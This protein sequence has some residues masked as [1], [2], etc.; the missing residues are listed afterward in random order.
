[1]IPRSLVVMCFIV[2][3]GAAVAR[4]TP[5]GAGTR[6][7]IVLVMA[8]DLGFSDLGCYGGEIDT[9]HIDRLAQEGIRFSNFHVNSMCVV[10]RTSLLSGHTHYQSDGYRHSLPIA[11]RMRRAG[12]R[13]S[14]S[15]K[16]HQPGHPL[17]AG[18]DHFYGFLKGQIN[19]WTGVGYGQDSIQTDRENPRSVPAGWYAGDAFTEH[20]IRQ[21]DKA[22]AADK[23]FFS[24]VAYNAPHTPLHAPRENV[25]K[26]PP[27]YRAGW[28]ALR[29]KRCERLKSLG[30]IDGRY[31]QVE[32]GAE[33]RRWD[34]LRPE[35]R[36]IEANRMA[37]YAGM[38]DRLDENVGRLI[39]HLREKGVL[40]HTLVLFLS[41]NGGDYGN[42]HIQTYADQV[43]WEKNT[44]P[45][46]SN[47]W[48]WLKNTPFNWY[49]HSEGGGVRSPLILRWPEGIPHTPGTI[50]PHRLHITD[51]YPTF[52][53]L[54]GAEYPAQHGS[55]EL[56][57]LYGRSMVPLF[58]TASLDG[59]AIRDEIFWYYGDGVGQ[60]ALLKGDWKLMSLN[61]GPWMLFNVETDPGESRNMAALNPRK[62][63][64]LSDRWYQFAR[65][66]AQLPPVGLKPLRSEQEGWGYH[67]VA[68]MLPGLQ[69]LTPH[70]AE[71]GVARNT[72]L[73]LEFDR[74]VSFAGT[75]GKTL[76]LYAVGDP[77]HP[78]WQVDP[79]P[80][81]EWQG[82]TRVVFDNL[83]LLKPDTSYFLL[84]DAG[85]MLIDAR[86]A[87]P[88]NDGA[89][90]WRFRTK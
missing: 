13:T 82:K 3:L 1:M 68:R 65:E 52:L 12:Y 71:T 36:E 25:E 8:D 22:L 85:W 88:L 75:K 9:P 84:A 53:E 23:P 2:V 35:D 37:A 45:H 61:D 55:R 14:V 24:F 89:Y 38:V 54:A 78:L 81:S 56:K 15:G 6:P 26:Y 27:H 87:G 10:T 17:D 50:L 47:G 4:G 40:D 28:H 29:K 18:F 64:A 41:D 31:H 21:I 58:S 63:Q 39:G 48:G 7:N 62:V 11:E 34:E 79:E 69:G 57:R 74:P 43:P 90:W 77:V 16:W 80:D 67:R 86:K 20:A 72:D 76:R 70:Q 66:E 83:P 59:Y 73:V 30:L 19:S 32:P 51:L 5:T 60:R 49:K 33:V 42:G 44:T 46:V